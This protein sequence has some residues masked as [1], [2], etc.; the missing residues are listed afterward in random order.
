MPCII[1]LNEM[2]HIR[3]GLIRVF[4]DYSNINYINDR[5]GKRT[6]TYIFGACCAIE[7]CSFMAE[8]VNSYGIYYLNNLFL[9]ILDLCDS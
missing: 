6:W 1:F 3:A 2:R 8:G 7:Q 5:L 4:T 9:S